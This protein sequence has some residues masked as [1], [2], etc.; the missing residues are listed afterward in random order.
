MAVGIKN[1][2][3]KEVRKCD[4]FYNC[5]FPQKVIDQAISHITFTERMTCTQTIARR[6]NLSNT[7]SNKTVPKIILRN[8]QI[9]QCD[10]ETAFLFNPLNSAELLAASFA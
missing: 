2:S 9:L 8:F 7:L 3:P 10:L 4:Y 6:E 1:F 5:G